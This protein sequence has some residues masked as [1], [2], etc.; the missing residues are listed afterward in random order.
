MITLC[1]HYIAYC[2]NEIDQNWYEFDDNIVSRVDAAEVLTKE[3]YVLFYQKKNNQI[4]QIREKYQSISE[5]D[6][7]VKVISF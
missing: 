5:I 4:I 6:T 2:R 7:I 1:G 3:A